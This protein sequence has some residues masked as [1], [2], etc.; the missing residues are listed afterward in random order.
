MCGAEPETVDH[1]LVGCVVSKFLLFSLF[2]ESQLFPIFED[3]SFVW[4]RLLDWHPHSDAAKAQLL[5]AATWWMLWLER[6]NIFFRNQPTDVIQIS[7]SIGVLAKEWAD[8]S[9]VG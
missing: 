9:R 8:F 5:V 7:H 3:I 4:G 2:M 1:L 6:N